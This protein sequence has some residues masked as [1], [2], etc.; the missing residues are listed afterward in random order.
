MIATAAPEKKKQ[1]TSEDAW[2]QAAAIDAAV[3]QTMDNLFQ[4]Y[5][6]RMDKKHEG[7]DKDIRDYTPIEL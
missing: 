5:G 7:S 4:D 6:L 1:Q 3:T 2:A